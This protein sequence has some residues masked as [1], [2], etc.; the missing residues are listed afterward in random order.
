MKQVVNKVVT[1][2]WR[3]VLKRW[4]FWLAT[5]GTAVTTF[6]L[7]APD[8]VLQMWIILPQDL[9]SVLPVEFVRYFGIALFIASNA[10][11]LIKQRKPQP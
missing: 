9:K 11:A 3:D 5:A 6:A 4:S 1:P 7:S 10:A 8:T 2:N